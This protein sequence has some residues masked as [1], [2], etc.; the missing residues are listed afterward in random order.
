MRTGF[1]DFDFSVVDLLHDDLGA[2]LVHSASD[3]KASAQYGFYCSRQGF[4]QWFFFH[5]SGD[6][7]HLLE[8]KVPLVSHVLHFL[9]VSLIASQFFDDESWGSRLNC[10]LCGPILALELNHDSDSLPLSSFLYNVFTDFLG[11]QTK[12]TQ[13]RGES[14]GGTGF[15]SED[16]DVNC[17]YIG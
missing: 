9:S 3:G 7:L 14:S 2:H 8:S 6:L 4:G 10:N 16:F 1:S 5:G 15:S 13:L 17:D 12:R 11:I